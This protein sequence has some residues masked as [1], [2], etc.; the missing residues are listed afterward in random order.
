TKRHE[1]NRR[2][3]FGPTQTKRHEDNRRREFGPTQT[4]R[5]EDNRRME[6]RCSTNKVRATRDWKIPKNN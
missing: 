4:K 2:R 5:H 3:E 6:F 1:D